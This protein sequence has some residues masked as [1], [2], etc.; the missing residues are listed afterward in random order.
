M[1]T[2]LLYKK[3]KLYQKWR[4]HQKLKL[5]QKLRI[6]P[7][8]KSTQNLRFLKRLKLILKRPESETKSKVQVVPEVKTQR[9]QEPK[10]KSKIVNP[11][12][13]NGSGTKPQNHPRPKVQNSLK[14]AFQKPNYS[15]VKH[16]VQQKNK[17][18]RTN[19]KGP[20]QKW[21]PKL[22]IVY[23]SEKSFRKEVA[24]PKS[25]VQ[26]NCKGRK[27]YVPKKYFE[28]KDSYWREYLV[29]CSHDD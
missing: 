27:A 8:L 1:L 28:T 12:R 21:V 18:F 9:K 11:S 24:L 14:T 17:I 5:H 7:K 13:V 3:S 6:L 25:L 16:K 29:E 4:L 22:E 10:T 2:R 23:S 26:V 15:P 19:Q 20:I